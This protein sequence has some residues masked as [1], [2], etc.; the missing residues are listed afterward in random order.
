[1]PAGCGPEDAEVVAVNDVGGSCT[2]RGECDGTSMSMNKS[3]V[4]MDRWIYMKQGMTALN[5]IVD[6][7]PGPE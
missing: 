3:Q 1:V 6:E 2:H 5:Q 4:K 7:L